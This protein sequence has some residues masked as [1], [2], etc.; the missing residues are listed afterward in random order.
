MLIY[1]KILNVKKIQI[2]MF[3]QVDWWNGKGRKYISKL[4]KY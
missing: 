1:G 2:V 3:G 4:N